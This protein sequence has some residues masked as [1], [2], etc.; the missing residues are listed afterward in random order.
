M[1]KQCKFL[2]W[3]Q[4]APGHIPD[5]HAKAQKSRQWC[6]FHIEG[7]HKFLDG[8][9]EYVV[10]KIVVSWNN[11]A[12]IDPAL[13]LLLQ[14]IFVL[15]TLL[16]S[17]K[18]WIHFASLSQSIQYC[19]LESPRKNFCKKLS[20]LW[21]NKCLGPLFLPPSLKGAMGMELYNLWGHT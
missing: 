3:S 4:L 17:I 18:A 10:S 19:A 1:N 14:G 20:P 6:T 12:R 8:P 21:I 9:E 16:C 7:W 13:T 11:D 2:S 15:F 5:P